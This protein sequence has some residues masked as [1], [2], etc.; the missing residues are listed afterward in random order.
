M[1]EFIA[2]LERIAD[3]IG[4]KCETHAE[5]VVSDMVARSFGI[6]RKSTESLYSNP[7]TGGQH[8]A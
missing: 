7:K 1:N 2:D 4:A 8:N 3:E 6:H 5:K